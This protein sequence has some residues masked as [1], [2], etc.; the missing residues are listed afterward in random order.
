MPAESFMSISCPTASTICCHFMARQV[1]S[2]HMVLIAGA[3]IVKHSSSRPCMSSLMRLPPIS[4]NL[5]EMP[6]DRHVDAGPHC[7]H[8]RASST[9]YHQNR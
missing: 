5:T 6:I 1:C 7:I 8:A 9:L 2:L 3:S 4:S